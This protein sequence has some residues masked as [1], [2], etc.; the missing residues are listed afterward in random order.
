M[1]NTLQV[2]NSR[3]DTEKWITELEH[4]VVDIT[5][6]ERKRKKELNENSLRD[7]WDNIK[8]TNSHHRN[9]RRR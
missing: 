3:N 8:N 4:R 2:I 7:L 6:S 1:K 5:K 9:S